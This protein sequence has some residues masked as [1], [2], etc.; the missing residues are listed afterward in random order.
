MNSTSSA[1]SLFAPACVLTHL[2]FRGNSSCSDRMSVRRLDELIPDRVSAEMAVLNLLHHTFRERYG[3]IRIRRER[4]LLKRKLIASN[5]LDKNSR[6]TSSATGNLLNTCDIGA[7]SSSKTNSSAAIASHNF[8]AASPGGRLSRVAPQADAGM[9][10]PSLAPNNRTGRRHATVS[11][12]TPFCR[13]AKA[14]T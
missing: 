7:Y 13:R 11:A 14:M 9:T 4:T 3:A 2:P 10:I 5:Y 1:F 8:V 6:G 12:A